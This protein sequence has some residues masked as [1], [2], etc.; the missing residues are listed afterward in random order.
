MA[1]LMCSEQERTSQ[2][3][4]PRVDFYSTIE[5]DGSSY[6]DETVSEI[7]SEIPVASNNDSVGKKS[8]TNRSQSHLS[9]GSKNTI[10]SHLS[11]PRYLSRPSSQWSLSRPP[12][13]IS[14]PRTSTDKLVA[15]PETL[16][17][18]QGF[19][20]VKAS[21][22]RTVKR[23]PSMRRRV[24]IASPAFISFLTWASML[25]YFQV[26]FLGLDREEDGSFRRI[27]FTYGGYP[28]VSCIGAIRQTAFKTCC[29]IVAC[30]TWWVFAFDFWIG[31]RARTFPSM[32]GH[33][34]FYIVARSLK[35]FAGICGGAFLI[36]LSFANVED[37]SQHDTHLILTTLQVIGMGGTRFW[38]FFACREMVKRMEAA[39]ESMP[40]T[41]AQSKA[42]KNLEGIVCMFGT[43]VLLPAI[44]G[45]S[46]EGQILSIDPKVVKQ[47]AHCYAMLSYAAVFEWIM[48]VGWLFYMLSTAWD[49]VYLWDWI[50]E[51][52]KVPAIEI[53]RSSERN[54]LPR[55][56][57]F[58]RK[59][60]RV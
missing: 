7:D 18:S 17:S 16:Y 26:Y 5:Y 34:W 31:S 60:S 3:D 55:S 10:S 25:I 19:L 15:N 14:N 33:A 58:F 28:F 36:G 21:P 46:S 54:W 32:K 29:I 20:D 45:C 53:K 56:P 27:G 59:Y 43:T 2:L 12:S 4:P 22:Q 42:A 8:K 24:L 48:S 49:L 38:D 6:D 39:G 35:L 44:Y 30:C 11:P 40:K 13:Y 41:M 1:S 23:V 9:V 37:G 47:S 51:L 50:E 57:R 52:R